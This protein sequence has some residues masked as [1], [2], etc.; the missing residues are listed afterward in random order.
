VVTI[1]RKG[2]QLKSLHEGNGT[3][4]VQVLFD[5]RSHPLTAFAVAYFRA[6]GPMRGGGRLTVQSKGRFF[7]RPGPGGWAIYAFEVLRKDR[8]KGR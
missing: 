5:R 6:S 3:L 4:R 7:L 1:G 8:T 2:R